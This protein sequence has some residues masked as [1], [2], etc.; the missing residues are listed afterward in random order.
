MLDPYTVQQ[1]AKVR[2]QEILDEAEWYRSSVP[3]PSRLRQRLGMALI[4]LG[5]KLANAANLGADRDVISPSG[6]PKVRG[7]HGDL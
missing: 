6:I 1:L 5:Q 3:M 4:A 7:L 2:Q